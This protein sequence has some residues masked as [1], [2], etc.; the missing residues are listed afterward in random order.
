MEGP[1]LYSEAGG[2]GSPVVIKATNLA[3]D[4]A[5]LAEK[6]KV[7]AGVKIEDAGG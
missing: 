1:T 4:V 2:G 3:V 7:P 5:V 6:F